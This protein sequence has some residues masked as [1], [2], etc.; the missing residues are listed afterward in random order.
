MPGRIGRDSFLE[1]CW[2]RPGTRLVVQHEREAGF[3]QVVSRSGNGC[4]GCFGCLVVI[5]LLAIFLPGVLIFGT[6]RLLD[7]LI[8]IAALF[9]ESGLLEEIEAI[10]DDPGEDQ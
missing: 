7:T 1:S 6:G 9:H 3:S 10:L 2:Q 4:A 8:E 5:I